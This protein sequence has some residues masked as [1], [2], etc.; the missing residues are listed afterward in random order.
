MKDVTCTGVFFLMF[1]LFIKKWI[2][3]LGQVLIKSNA[4][5]SVC[6]DGPD[7][8]AAIAILNCVVKFWN[9]TTV[10]WHLLQLHNIHTVSA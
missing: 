3:H 1:C 6:V 4:C 8:G 5:V 10:H 7:G 2:L 9:W